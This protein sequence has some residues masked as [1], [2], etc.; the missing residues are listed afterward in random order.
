MLLLKQLS[1]NG[2]V[3][4]YATRYHGIHVHYHPDGKVYV[5]SNDVD[6]LNDLWDD[7]VFNNEI[8]KIIEKIRS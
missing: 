6:V 4:I 2:D 8:D 5:E 7:E 1:V 3:K